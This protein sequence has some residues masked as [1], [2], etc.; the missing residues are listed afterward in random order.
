[1]PRCLNCPTPPKKGYYYNG[2]ENT[3]LGK[4]YSA[5]FE[6]EGKRMKGNDGKMYTVKNGK[7]IAVN[8]SSPRGAFYSSHISDEMRRIRQYCDTYRLPCSDKLMKLS[9]LILKEFPGTKVS[10]AIK[11]ARER[12][13]IDSGNQYHYDYS[14]E[15]QLVE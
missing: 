7:W 1:M 6:K 15:G 11:V 2:E 5:R 4:G 14:K 13:R 12:I 8:K 10:T 9:E 3:P